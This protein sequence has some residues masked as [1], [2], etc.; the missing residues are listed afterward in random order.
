MLWFRGRSDLDFH[1]LWNWRN[2]R[3]CRECT[4]TVS[5]DKAWPHL[6][7]QTFNKYIND[8]PGA[9]DD[10]DDVK[11]PDTVKTRVFKIL[12]EIRHAWTSCWSK[13]IYLFICEHLV[14]IK[15]HFIFLIWRYQF[16]YNNNNI[17]LIKIILTNVS[18]NNYNNIHNITVI[19]N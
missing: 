7:H 18:I 14:N 10:D 12:R 11:S 4:D 5:W 1:M 2:E 9:A 19:Y 15:N 8:I 3:N 6:P 13:S 16:L 17:F